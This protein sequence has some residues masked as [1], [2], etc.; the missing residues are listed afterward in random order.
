MI[1]E[2]SIYDAYFPPPSCRQGARAAAPFLWE[3]DKCHARATPAS[4]RPKVAYTP[5]HIRAMAAPRQCPVPPGRNCAPASGPRPV[6]VRCRFSLGVATPPDTQVGGQQGW[7]RRLHSIIGW[8]GGGTDLHMRNASNRKAS[9]TAKEKA[10]HPACSCNRIPPFPYRS[11]DTPGPRALRKTGGGAALWP[12]RFTTKRAMAFTVGIWKAVRYAQTLPALVRE[13]WQDVG[14]VICRSG[15]RNFTLVFISM[16]LF[17]D[18]RR[19]LLHLPQLSNCSDC[20]RPEAERWTPNGII[21]TGG[22]AAADEN[23]RSP[24]GHPAQRGAEQPRRRRGR[25]HITAIRREDSPLRRAESA[26]FMR[27]FA[28]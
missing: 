23:A 5:R 24:K 19:R 1:M 14:T 13:R 16:G 20:P 9:G 2:L 25:R 27:V 22:M 6:H 3:Q 26:G 15:P 10:S 21:G 17:V 11:H 12:P 18:H 28:P 8:W 7:S 4:P